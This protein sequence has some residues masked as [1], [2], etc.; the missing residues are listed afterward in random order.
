M[1]SNSLD[2]TLKSILNTLPRT[3][4]PLEAIKILRNK[5]LKKKLKI[6]S[7]FLSIENFRAEHC[8]YTEKNNAVLKIAK[9][10]KRD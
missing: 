10:N 6:K 9:R 3:L 7:G 1:D 5:N 4:A 8:D 2:K